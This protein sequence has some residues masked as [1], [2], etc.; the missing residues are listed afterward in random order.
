[1]S[2]KW[3]ALAAGY[4]R[5]KEIISIKQNNVE[6]AIYDHVARGEWEEVSSN[7][8]KQIP[9]SRMELLWDILVESDL[10]DLNQLEEK[11][12]RYGRS[13]GT[14]DSIGRTIFTRMA[15]TL[16]NA[17]NVKAQ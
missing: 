4:K 7:L 10:T 17:Q 3:G 11:I 9:S 8:A 13:L 15:L 2:K 6:Q 16:R 14:K 12:Y 5:R 1:V